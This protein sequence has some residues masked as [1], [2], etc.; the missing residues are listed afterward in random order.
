MINR[1][2]IKE[3]LQTAAKHYPHGAKAKSIDRHG[4]E[5]AV[6]REILYMIADGIAALKLTRYPKHPGLKAQ[7][8]DVRDR[9]RAAVAA[10]NEVFWS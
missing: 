8:T 3:E 6:D 7:L 5:M 10:L 9:S 4:I 1:Q 2:Q